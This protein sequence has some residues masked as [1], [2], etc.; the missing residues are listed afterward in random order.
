MIRG[1][2]VS[3]VGST[4][5][6]R[7]LG[8]LRRYPALFGGSSEDTVPGL[9]DVQ[10]TRSVRVVRF[11]YHHRGLPVFGGQVVVVLDQSGRVRRVS[12]N[13]EPLKLPAKA[14]QPR[15]TA[16]AAVRIACSAINRPTPASA[17]PTWAQLGILAQG[18]PRLIYRVALPPTLDRQVSWHRVDARTGEYVGRRRATVSHAGAGPAVVEVKR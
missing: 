8:F 17:R 6:Q 18:R 9:I 12:S 10:T 13:L 1:L 15:L 3:T 7:A 16:L 14:V 4:D 5:E 11:R 2:K